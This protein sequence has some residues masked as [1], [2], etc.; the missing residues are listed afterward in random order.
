MYVLPRNGLWEREKPYLLKFKP[1]V[2]FPKTNISMVKLDGIQ[3]EDTRGKEHN[4]S[5]ERNGFAI[6]NLDIA[7]SPELFDDHETVQSAF[8]PEA[9]EALKS[10]LGASRVQV[11]DYVVCR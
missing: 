10:F 5:L 8:L 9:A 2:D 4:L 11:F 6:M 3:I 1:T 7:M